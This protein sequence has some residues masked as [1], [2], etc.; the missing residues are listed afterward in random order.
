MQNKALDEILTSLSNPGLE[1]QVLGE[2]LTYTEDE[3]V[4]S[5]VASLNVGAFSTPDYFK[6]FK[7]LKQ[8]H[9]SGMAIDLMNLYTELAKAYPPTEVQRLHVL[10]IGF[11]AVSSVHI[12]AHADA[13]TQLYLRRKYIENRIRSIDR[14]SDASVPLEEVEREEEAEREALSND[15]GARFRDILTTEQSEDD[16][17][18]PFADRTPE[19]ETHYTFARSDG[20]NRET[21]TLPTGALTFVCAP[22]SHGKSTF[23]QNL[24]LDVARSNNGYVLYFTYE[25]CRDDV[26][27]QF[28]N[29]YIGKD[30]SRSNIASI[31]HYAM[32]KND[33]MIMRDMRPTFHQQTGKFI[34][35]LIQTGKLNIIYKNYDCAKLAEAI[36]EANRQLK[37]NGK[38]ISAVFIDY[39]QL[40]WIEDNK[41]QRR[42][43]LR[44]I[45]QI[46]RTTAIK[47]QVPIVLA[48][49]LN[50]E[51]M[52]PLLLFNEYIAEAADLE[53]E[54]NKVICL[55]NTSFKSRLTSD[56]NKADIESWEAE[57]DVKLGETDPTHIFAVL[58]K[59]RGSMRGLEAVWEY[60]GNSGKITDK[61]STSL[62]KPQ[63][64]TIFDKD[65][66]NDEDLYF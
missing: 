55:W 66:G 23:C 41:K 10:A 13:L 65:N 37:Q 38:Y 6:I 64:Q 61:Y 8:M 4:T 47:L 25:E 36:C 7:T 24:A 57:H 18:A 20:K 28:L 44:D 52:S 34:S 2:I 26:K 22:T 31:R 11:N 35:E 16:F 45:A 59:N 42:E 63:E 53:R 58:T 21:L 56:K 33:E 39:V 15:R 3:D 29:K 51:A 12:Q 9:N 62:S 32:T 46:L 54:A 50:R 40:L 43:E 17:F 14:L 30:I 60:H 49:Q 5:I 1:K 27:L 19:V 48:A